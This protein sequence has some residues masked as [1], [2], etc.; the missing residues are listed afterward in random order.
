MKK[1]NNY[2]FQQQQQKKQE[3][4][5]TKQIKKKYDEMPVDATE[6]IEY[7]KKLLSGENV[8]KYGPEEPEKEQ[9]DEYFGWVTSGSIGF[10]SKSHSIPHTQMHPL[11]TG[12]SLSDVLDALSP[13]KT[14]S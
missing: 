5:K 4:K 2:R 13:K 1:I 7:I 9:P 8:G 14:K 3:Y 12:M 10:R 11:P 6:E